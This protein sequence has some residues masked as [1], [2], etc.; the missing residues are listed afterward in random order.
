ME[1]LLNRLDKLFTISS[2]VTL[3]VTVVFAILSIEGCIEQ[4]QFMTVYLMIIT[5]YFGTQAAKSKE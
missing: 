3:I 4:Q 5:F 1:T 2:I